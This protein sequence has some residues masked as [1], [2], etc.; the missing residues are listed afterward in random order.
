MKNKSKKGFS[1]VELLVVITIIAILSVVA[2][3]AVGGQ[4][5]NARNSRRLQDINTIQ[6]ALEV[7]LIKNVNYPSALDDM[8]KDVISSIPTDPSGANYYYKRGDGAGGDGDSKK[9]YI[10]AATL[11]ETDTD[12]KVAYVVTN[13]DN[14][15]LINFT[16]DNDPP[17]ACTVGETLVN[18]DVCFPYNP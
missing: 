7:Y 1:L 4:T 18:L 15:Q 17:T 14:F 11:E 5:A 16:N 9:T 13:D 8:G 3:M 6:Q 12:D 2:Y 10:L